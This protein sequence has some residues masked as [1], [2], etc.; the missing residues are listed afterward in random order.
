MATLT[1]IEFEG[2]IFTKSF[3]MFCDMKTFKSTAWLLPQPVRIIDT[4]EKEG[5]PNAMNA[6]WWNS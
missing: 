4:Y 3:N 1:F 2:T 6:A 5:K